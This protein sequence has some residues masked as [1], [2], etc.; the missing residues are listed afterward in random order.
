TAL[1]QSS[2]THP[3]ERLTGRRAAAVYLAYALL[4]IG[5]DASA[6]LFEIV[7]G[8]SLWYPPVGLALALAT[9]V[10]LR[11]APIVLVT[12]LVSSYVTGGSPSSWTQ[13]ALPLLI[14]VA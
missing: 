4:H 13:L 12:Q 14:T 2:S 10:G 8:V 1:V 3:L 7:P 5:F 9:I 11:S 6:R